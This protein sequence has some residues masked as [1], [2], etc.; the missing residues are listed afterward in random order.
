MNRVDLTKRKKKA[1]QSINEQKETGGWWICLWSWLGDG[2]MDDYF[3]TYQVVY[4]KISTA[5]R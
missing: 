4:I 3:P 5:L 1:N 2:L